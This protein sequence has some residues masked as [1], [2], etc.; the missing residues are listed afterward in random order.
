LVAVLQ[1]NANLDEIGSNGT[2]FLDKPSQCL[3]DTL[4]FFVRR[5]PALFDRCGKLEQVVVCFGQ[6][7]SLKSPSPT[8][9]GTP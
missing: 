3:K 4:A 6:D 5:N 2:A 1:S 8:P 9:S 7:T